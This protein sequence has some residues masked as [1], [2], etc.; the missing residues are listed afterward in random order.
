MKFT[1]EI[2]PHGWSSATLSDSHETVTMS[3]SHVDVSV[4]STEKPLD[5]LL[6]AV[7][8]I[9]DGADSSKV[10][11]NEEPELVEWLFVR[12]GDFVVLTVTRVFDHWME[13]VERERMVIFTSSGSVASV[14]ET[15]ATGAAAAIHEFEQLPDNRG[16]WRRPLPK[17]L[18]K[19]LQRS[20]N[21]AKR[22]THR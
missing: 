6:R 12:T 18:L 20:L 16:P 5:G 14:G 21:R 7:I 10:V 9:V 15:I 4:E 13:A 1:Y 17:R 19:R 2:E 11:W 8:E 3:A 22:S